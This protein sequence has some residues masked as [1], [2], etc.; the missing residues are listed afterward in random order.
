MNWTLTRYISRLFLGNMAAVVIGFAGLLQLLD[1]LNNTD[2]LF[3]RHGD[4]I[5]VLARYT[6]LRMPEVIGFVLPF[7]TLLATLL[8]LARLAQ[9]SEILAAKAAG[10]SFYRLLFCFMPT[11]ALIAVASF[12]VVDR[13]TPLTQRAL[14]EWDSEAASLSG[15]PAREISDGV[16]IRDGQALVRVSIVLNQGRELHDVTFFVR[17]EGGNLVKRITAD[18]ALYLEQ[19]RWQL[20]DVEQLV[21]VRHAGG[22]F[23]RHASDLWEGTLVPGHYADIVAPP[24]SLTLDQLESFTRSD[25][26]IGNRPD[27]YYETWLHKRYAVPVAIFIMV[28]LAAPMAQTL[29]RNQRMATGLVAGVGMGFLYF[30]TEGVCQALGETG[31][32]PAIVAAWSPGLLFLSFGVA[33]LIRIEGY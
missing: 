23:T 4:S 17:D 14:I 3:S 12:Y 16:W 15:K 20:Y 33:G 8:T 2:R 28:I 22:E 19:G 6:M 27:Y 29:R 21:M 9:N 26:E 5:W 7:S 24:T 18:V 25:G 31:A 10:L 30:V 1:L 32:I 11:A 13:A